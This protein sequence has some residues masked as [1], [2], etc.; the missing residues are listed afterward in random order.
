MS[1]LTNLVAYWKFDEASG[2]AADAQGSNT[3]TDNGSVGSATGI[4]N[5][6]RSFTAASS[7]YFEAADNADLS[8]ADIDFT[9]AF[10]FKANSQPG[11]MEI[12]SKDDFSTNREYSIR[13]INAT[14]RFTIVG[15]GGSNVNASTDTWS[16]GGWY[17][18]ICWHDSVANTSNVQINDGTAHSSS[19]TFGGQD[20]AA[21]FEIGRRV[22]VGNYFDGLIDEVGFWKRVLTSQERTDLYNGGAGFAY[23]FVTTAL[24]AKGVFVNQ[25]IM[26]TF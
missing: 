21:S 11:S 1:L 6:A 4:I 9:F 18:V 5:N 19:Y 14:I 20:K 25:A 8:V 13:T 16:T 10:W 26:S 23:P 3:L 15:S 2:N 12:I 17:Y 7:Q 24:T 22:D